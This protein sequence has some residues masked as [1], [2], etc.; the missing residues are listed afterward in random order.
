MDYKTAGVDIEKGDRFV[1]SIKNLV[2]STMNEKVVS[3]I[4]GFAALYEVRPNF[5]LA[6]ATDGVGTKLR[7]AQV[8]NKH[9]SIGI[10]LVAMCVN[11]LICVGARPLFFLDYYA[12]GK[13][14]EEHGFEIVKGIVDGCKQSS[15]ALIGG[16]TAEM[17]GIYKD[18]DYDLA[19]FCVGEATK[20]DL[21]PIE[22]IVDGDRVIGLASSGFH[23]NAY[24]LVRKMIHD[25]ET[26]IQS[27]ALTPTRIY[28]DLIQSLRQKFGSSI[29]GLAHITGGGW[30]NLLRLRD[31]FSFCIEHKPQNLPAPMP[32][33][34]SRL[35]LPDEELY[36]TF[37]M[38]VGLML[39]TDREKEVL[40]FLQEQQEQ[41]WSL[42]FLQKGEKK[43]KFLE[44][45]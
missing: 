13:L 20:E 21:L 8:L 44:N 2:Q 19:G 4:G 14:N 27:Q 32:E 37:N 28:V 16:E 6:S 38:G 26:E 40:E 22:S 11:D 23:S 7:L 17:P 33:I 35:D 29:K 36:R 30:E 3:G 10:D 43:L 15:M 12:T 42:G 45:Q 18:E 34:L 41:A 5:Y 25:D 24:S 1:G 9:D 31:D 39:V